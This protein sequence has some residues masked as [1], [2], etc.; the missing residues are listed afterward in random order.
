MLGAVLIGVSAAMGVA[1]AEDDPIAPHFGTAAGG[2]VA[3]GSH[4]YFV[5]S[6]LRLPLVNIE[7]VLFSYRYRETT[8][9]VNAFDQV[10]AEV[11]YRRNE[12]QADLK[13]NDSVRAIALAGYE[14]TGTIDRH[15]LLSAYALGAGLGSWPPS[16]N[17]RLNWSV[18]AGKYVSS[19]GTDADWWSD[20][21]VSW[22]VWEFGEDRYRDSRFRPALVLNA[23]VE[24]ANHGGELHELTRIGPAIQLMTANG[25]RASL[26]LEWYHND[27][28]QFYGSDENGWLVTFRVDSTLETNHVFHARQERESGWLPLVWGEYDVGIGDTRRISRFDMNVELVDFAIRDQLFTAFVWYESRQEYRLGDFDSIAYSVTLGLQTP[29]GLESVASHGDPVVLG[30]DFLHRSDHSL[31]PDAS[32]VPSGNFLDNGSHNLLPRL[33]L[34]T[35]G[36]DLP[37]RDPGMYRRATRWLNLFDW[38]VTAGLDVRDSRDRGKFAG[39]LGLNWD[40]ATLDGCVVYLLGIGSIGNETPDWLGEFGLRRPAGKVFV[41]CERYGM[42]PSIGRG[43]TLVLGIGVNL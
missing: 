5:E 10:R 28:N 6:E 1:A 27:G 35:T 21:N 2:F 11:L 20:L 34:Q 41:R 18:L 15:G 31:N 19:Q 42:Q 4:D 36:W 24:S 22:R 7:P 3:G 40:A 33:R 29:L 13:L 26:Q 25:N 8:P 39:Q 38:R 9:F 37:Y 12:L 23:S 16:N 43:D 14:S 30:A 32:R 17:G